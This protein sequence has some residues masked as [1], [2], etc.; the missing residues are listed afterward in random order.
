MQIVYE[1]FTVVE[2]FVCV[3]VR[4]LNE[5]RHID[6]LHAQKTNQRQ[7]RM[8]HHHRRRVG[9]QAI[10]RHVGE[11]DRAARDTDACDLVVAVHLNCAVGRRGGVEYQRVEIATEPEVEERKRFVGRRDDEGGRRVDSLGGGADG[12][13]VVGGV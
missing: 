2:L 12:N 1:Q 6:P 8:R 4:G 7:H 10:W 11:I 9:L 3:L 5:E 13:A